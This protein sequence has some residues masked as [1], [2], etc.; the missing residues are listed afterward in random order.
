MERAEISR[1]HG[2]PGRKGLLALV[3]S[4]DVEFAGRNV[5]A[6]WQRLAECRRFDVPKRVQ[7][8]DRARQPLHDG[9]RPF[10]PLRAHSKRQHAAGVQTEVHVLDLCEAAHEQTGACEEHDR[11]RHLSGNERPR[12]PLAA[13]DVPASA[14][15]QRFR[16]RPGRRLQGRHERKPQRCRGADDERECHQADVN[17]DVAQLGERAGRRAKKA[18]APRGDHES[19]SGARDREQDT[20]AE[21][22]AHHADSIRAEREA[23][24]HLVLP[25]RRVRQ[26]QTRHVAARGKQDERNGPEQEPER[27]ADAADLLLLERHE[28]R[29]PSSVGGRILLAEASFDRV[30]IRLCLCERGA[31][32]QP[33]DRGVEP[34]GARGEKNLWRLRW[35]P[36]LGRRRW[37]AEGRRHH[38]DDCATRARERQAP[39]DGARIAV[40]T[41][42]PET[43]ADDR[44]RGAPKAFFVAGR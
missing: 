1:A 11:E 42:P 23:H 14:M 43:V 15:R 26:H 3:A 22:L 36:D 21:Q 10:A 24:R 6:S 13:A 8:I 27:T 30:E 18:E 16:R 29:T 32:L 5:D 19:E 44:D 4:E 38:G 9:G 20:F 31:L 12:E 28:R 41:A 17:G 39:A 33:S 35:Q 7:S 25:A 2:A 37:I 34:S 40:Q